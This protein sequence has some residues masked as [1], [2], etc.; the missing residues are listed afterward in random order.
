M[1]C[2]GVSDVSWDVCIIDFYNYQIFSK[3]KSLTALI[4]ISVLFLSLQTFRATAG[5]TLY[6]HFRVI[7]GSAF[8][9]NVID[10][11]TLSKD[12][13]SR[14]TSDYNG[15]TIKTGHSSVLELHYSAR[16]SAKN[17]A[18]SEIIIMDDYGRFFNLLT[19]GV[20]M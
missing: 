2:E 5:K 4:Y 17:P 13:L 16:G 6:I 3:V 19:S 15:K 7:A 20:K 8:E 1:Q 11:S 10:G 18:F 12:L 14:I 9:V